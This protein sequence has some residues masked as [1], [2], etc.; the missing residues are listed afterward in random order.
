MSHLVMLRYMGGRVVANFAVLERY[1]ASE[2]NIPIT[3][4]KKKQVVLNKKFYYF[5]RPRNIPAFHPVSLN[6]FGS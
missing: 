6:P 4:R 3:P 5:S 2:R 1:L